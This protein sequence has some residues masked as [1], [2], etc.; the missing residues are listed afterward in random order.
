MDGLQHELRALEHLFAQRACAT[1]QQRARP[2]TVLI[3]SRRQATRMVLV[4]CGHCHH[5]GIFV[6]TLPASAAPHRR[7]P[8]GYGDVSAMRRFL[9]TFDGDFLHLF[10][11]DSSGQLATD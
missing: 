1:C 8:V 5:R 6:V 2:D 3:L 10:G 4:T 7:A 11:P 9:S